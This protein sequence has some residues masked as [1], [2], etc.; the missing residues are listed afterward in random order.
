MGEDA[1]T[2]LRAPRSGAH[3][4][5]VR[6]LSPIVLRPSGGG[7]ERPLKGLCG[8]ELASLLGRLG[9]GQAAGAPTYSRVAPT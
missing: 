5:P 6:A 3:S 1:F 9:H 8:G 7:P 4:C 2:Q